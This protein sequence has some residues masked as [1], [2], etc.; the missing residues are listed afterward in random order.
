MF[1]RSKISAEL[2]MGCAEIMF[3]KLI[4]ERRRLFRTLKEKIEEQTQSAVSVTHN[5]LFNLR[6]E[7]FNEKISE[8]S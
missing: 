2:R 5:D 6:R 4:P 3:S 8:R 1:D 7:L